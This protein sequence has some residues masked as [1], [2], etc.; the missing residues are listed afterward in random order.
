MAG[1]SHRLQAECSAGHRQPAHWKNCHADKSR[2][3]E[4]HATS[5]GEW[6]RGVPLVVMHDLAMQHAHEGQRQQGED[7]TSDDDRVLS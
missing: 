6:R 2:E 4:E 7:D 1:E 5:L 3:T